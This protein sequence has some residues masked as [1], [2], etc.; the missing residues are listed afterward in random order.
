MASVAGLSERGLAQV[1]GRL[2][3]FADEVFDGATQR[4]EQRKWGGVYLRG[5]MFDGRRK[6]IEPTLLIN[7]AGGEYALGNV[8]RAIE[9]G[10]AALDPAYKLPPCSL[11]GDPF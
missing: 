4:S 10:Y 6:S 8:D 2:E 5:L 3:V 7:L 1:R 11:V 9:L